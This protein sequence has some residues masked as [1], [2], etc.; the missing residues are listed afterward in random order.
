MII[1]GRNPVKEAIKA[2]KTIDK[3]Y[4]IKGE[5]DAMLSSIFRDIKDEGIVVS[6]LD[7]VAMESLTEGGNHQGIAAQVTDFEYSDLDDIMSLAESQGQPALIVILDGI[8]DPHNLGAIIRSAE[9]FGAHGVVIQ[10][11]RSVTVNDTVIKVAS[12]ATE[13]IAIAKVTNINDAI[14]QLKERNVWVYATDFDG[15][16]PK[17]VNL[18]GN[19]AIVIGSE[20]EGIKRL[21]KELCD[22][23]VTIPQYGKINSLNASVATGVVL[24]EIVRQRYN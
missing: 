11:H 14:R 24:Y 8:T 22:D 1:Y 9:C 12:G 4:M 16:P 3:V 15:K 17:S 13:H 23:T 18:T 10:K 19:I 5:H 7:R 20:G 2:G 6:Y 21:T